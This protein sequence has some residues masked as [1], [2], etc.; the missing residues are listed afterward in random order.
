MM[1]PFFI[2]TKQRRLLKNLAMQAAF[3]PRH[4][5]QTVFIFSLIQQPQGFLHNEITTN[6]IS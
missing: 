1:P 4:A 5:L 3:I 6:P 2:Q